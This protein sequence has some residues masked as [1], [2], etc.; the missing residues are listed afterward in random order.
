MTYTYILKNRVLA[1]TPLAPMW[2]DT[3][4]LTHSIV[5]ICPDCGEAWGRVIVPGTEWLPMR[6]AC[7][8]HKGWYPDLFYSGS[9]IP[10]WQRSL[11]HLP[12]PVLAYEF[13]RLYDGAFYGVATLHLP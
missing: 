13:M 8:R 2:S 1:T 9:F 7:D 5:H 3:Q 11:Q 4:M 6:T 12:E 10:P